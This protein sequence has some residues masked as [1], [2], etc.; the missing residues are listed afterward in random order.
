MHNMYTHISRSYTTWYCK[1]H[2]N[3][4]GKTFGHTL[5]SRRHLISHN[6]GRTMGRLSWVIWRK[7]PAKYR[8]YT[9]YENIHLVEHMCCGCNKRIVSSMSKPYKQPLPL[10]SLLICLDNYLNQWELI[11]NL[12]LKDKRQQYFHQNAIICLWIHALDLPILFRVASLSQWIDPEGYE[13]NH[14]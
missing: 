6:H 1:H 10:P 8:E 11:I 2:N 5:N 9:V 7:I 14:Q 12:S 3:H 4:N 13:S